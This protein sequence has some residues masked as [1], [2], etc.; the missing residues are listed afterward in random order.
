MGLLSRRSPGLYLKKLMSSLLAQ[1]K[2]VSAEVELSYGGVPLKPL[3]RTYSERLMVVGSAAG[4]VKP[5]TGGGIYYGL[6]CADIA[7]DN[8]HRA[9]K[10]DA[11][12]AKNL[13]SYEKAW[14]RKLGRELKVGYWARK[15]Y[16]LL[17]DA[18]I[19]RIFGIIESNGIVEAL[20][21]DDD[22]SFDWHGRA[23]LRLIGHE[24]LSKVIETMKIPFPLGGR[25]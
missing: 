22:L 7:A 18:Q 24:A 9:L 6:L 15:F 5:T 14:K 23:V 1:G 19:D 21:K 16:E 25:G 17:S 20:L 3:A 13:A 2:I 12:S 8:L 10:N 4:Q 11:L